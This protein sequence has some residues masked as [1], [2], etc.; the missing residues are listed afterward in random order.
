MRV[1]G[2][3]LGVLP[4]GPL[5]T[6]PAWRGRVSAHGGS[7]SSVAASPAAP[8]WPACRGARLTQGPA[9]GDIASRGLAGLRSPSPRCRLDR[10]ARRSPP[11]SAAASG[12]AGP[13]WS[14][15]GSRRHRDPSGGSGVG[16]AS[17]ARAPVPAA[18]ASGRVRAAGAGRTCVCLC[19]SRTGG[20]P[21]GHSLN[22]LGT[23]TCI[24]HLNP[25]H[26]LV[27]PL[28]LQKPQRWRN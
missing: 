18:G 3:C 24:L 4:P 11:T 6:A 25:A 23:R 2:A 17:T 13:A 14:D 21:R 1:P 26:V 7:G 8:H 12:S 15:V 22:V 16:A 27:A 5:V 19:R 28:D 10:C 20:R 9:L